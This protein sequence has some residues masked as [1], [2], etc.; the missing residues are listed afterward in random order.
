MSSM[1]VMHALV[2]IMLHAA[3]CTEL[4]KAANARLQEL[5]LVTRGKDER[6]RDYTKVSMACGNVEVQENGTLA[7]LQLVKEEIVAAKKLQ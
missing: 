6:G 2:W 5:G 1:H 3:A 7:L 4:T